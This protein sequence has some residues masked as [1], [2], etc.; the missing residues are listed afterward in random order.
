MKYLFTILMISTCML[1][2]QAQKGKKTEARWQK[3]TTDKGSIKAHTSQFIMHIEGVGKSKQP[4]FTI[5][6]D[7]GQEVIGYTEVEWT[8][9]T[10]GGN[11]P[12]AYGGVPTF[13]QTVDTSNPPIVNI[14]TTVSSPQPDGSTK[15]KSESVSVNTATGD[16]GS[17]TVTT[18]VSPNGN[19]TVT[20]VD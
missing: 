11:S 10:D 1:S 19:V 9:L 18:T 8:Y 7:D 3:I 12:T 13:S 5:K 16:T 14:T 17:A 6:T 4:K 2:A 15:I 20:E